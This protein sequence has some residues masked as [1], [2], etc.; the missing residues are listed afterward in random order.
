MHTVLIGSLVLGWT[1]GF[2][3]KLVGRVVVGIAVC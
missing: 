3:V 2:G 1:E